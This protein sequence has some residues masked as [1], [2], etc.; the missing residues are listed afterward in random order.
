MDTELR[1]NPLADGEFRDHVRSLVESIGDAA[2][3]VQ[4]VLQ[5]RYPNATIQPRRS[6]KG[7]VWYVYRE[8]RWM[9]DG[10]IGAVL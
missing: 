5:E 10:L 8:G 1:V 4:T 3:A 9:G 2:D 6:E 7:R